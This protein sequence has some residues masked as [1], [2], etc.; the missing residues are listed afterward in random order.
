MTTQHTRLGRPRDEQLG[1][2]NVVKNKAVYC[3]SVPNFYFCKSG[4]T[5]ECGH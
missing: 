5:T 4:Y 1:N 3:M 2:L